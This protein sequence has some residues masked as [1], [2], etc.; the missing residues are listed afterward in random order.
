M[1]STCC[2]PGNTPASAVSTII[3]RLGQLEGRCTDTST[4]AKARRRTQV[5][6]IPMSSPCTTVSRPF[7]RD[8]R[9]AAY[10]FSPL[11]TAEPAKPQNATRLSWQTSAMS[12]YDAPL[13]LDYA[14][15]EPQA[16][17]VLELVFVGSLPKPTLGSPHSVGVTA[18]K[19]QAVPVQLLAN[20]QVCHL[21]QLIFSVSS[22]FRYGGC[23][24][25][26]ERLLLA[27]NAD[28]KVV[29]PSSSVCHCDWQPAR[30][31]PRASRPRRDRPHVQYC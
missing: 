9:V 18:T 4:P 19:T 6:R 22:C 3:L 7:V 24:A 11:T 12:F 29:A 13:I 26:L 5:R 30:R 21:C 25:G 8:V 17:Y 10:Y 28:A 1:R 31:V 27:A 23:C 15:L 14:D 20:G 16:S 2:S